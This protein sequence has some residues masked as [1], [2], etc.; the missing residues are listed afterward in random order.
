M[1]APLAGYGMRGAIWYQ[2]ENNGGRPGEYRELLTRMIQDWRAQW[3]QGD[4]PFIIQQ[5]V[6]NG[7]PPKEANQPASWAYLREAQMQVADT[8]PAWALP[9]AS[10]SATRA[11]FTR[12]IS[13]KSENASRASP[14]KRLTAKKSSPAA[15]V[16]KPQR[17]K[18]P[19]S[20]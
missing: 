5:L 13:K 20:A 2:G 7:A 6:N 4:L 16:S 8:V 12:R 19:P 17:S 3:G 10:N 14:W 11:P 9:R 18:V 15:R 1:I